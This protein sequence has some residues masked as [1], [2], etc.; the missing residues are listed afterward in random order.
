MTAGPA[1]SLG[2]NQ[3]TKLTAG[4]IAAV[5]GS[6]TR[7]MV[8][9]RQPGFQ[10]DYAGLALYDGSTKLAELDSFYGSGE[11]I[12]FID[13]STLIGCS[14]F[15]APSELIRYSV[16]STAITPGTNVR[17]VIAGSTRTRI[18]SGSG[19]IFASDGNALNATTLAPLGRYVGRYIGSYAVAPIP[20]PNGTNVW[21]LSYMTRAWLYWPSTGR[22]FNCVEPFRSAP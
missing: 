4:Q 17:D 12:A 22:R 3:I 16:T 15:L 11:S 6:S 9:R 8:S 10:S 20:D 13:H 19:R 21:F 14:N 2:K 1:V 5:P 7:Y 18:A